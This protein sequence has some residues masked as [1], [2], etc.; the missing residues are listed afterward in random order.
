MLCSPSVCFTRGM[1]VAGEG[2]FK[3]DHTTNFHEENCG[4]G[5]GNLILA[6]L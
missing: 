3:G 1:P 5:G 6:F 2:R 4:G